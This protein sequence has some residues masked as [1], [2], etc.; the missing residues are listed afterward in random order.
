M[1]LVTTQAL[2]ALLVSKWHYVQTMHA[3]IG[4]VIG[5]RLLCLCLNGTTFAATQTTL[6][7]LRPAQIKPKQ[8]NRDGTFT[9]CL[10]LFLPG[11]DAPVVHVR[12]SSDAMVIPQ[13]FATFYGGC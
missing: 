2:S 5:F 9:F 11:A 4:Y 12:A 8:W 3:I 7:V 13:S 10:S 6:T 1:Q